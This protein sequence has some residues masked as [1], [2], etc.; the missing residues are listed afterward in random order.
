MLQDNP[1]TQV[2]KSRATSS[3]SNEYKNKIILADKPINMT[4]ADAVYLL[5]RK[6]RLKKAGH[7]GTLD[8]KASGL[9][10]ICTDKMTKRIN[11]F[12]EYEKEYEGVFRIGAITKSFDTESE[13]E[14]IKD[15]SNISI[16]D[17]LKARE[18]FIGEIYQ[19]PPMYSALKYKGKPLYKLAR[20]GK[21][22]ERK[23]RMVQIKKLEIKRKSNTEVWF[24]VV[25]SKGTYI[26]ALANDY[27][28]KLGVGAYLKSLRRIRIGDFYLEKFEREVEGL[29]F[30][31][32]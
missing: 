19:V 6:L 16:E 22:I 23:P 1:S 27:G 4:S 7:A 21:S 9:L 30:K 3:P 24:N 29:K 2:K 25:C 10:I 5:K 26:R 13:E 14:E 31:V 12:M 8:P 17:L 15:V 28:E 32:V 11:E 20:K 18:L